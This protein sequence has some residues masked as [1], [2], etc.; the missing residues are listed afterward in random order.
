MR[1]SNT[2]NNLIVAKPPIS[3]TYCIYGIYS[4]METVAERNKA[5]KKERS[6]NLTHLGVKYYGFII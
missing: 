6:F 2:D 4:L 5:R 3:I 1:D